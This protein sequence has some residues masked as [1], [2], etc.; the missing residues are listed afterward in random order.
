MLGDIRLDI[1]EVIGDDPAAPLLVVN[2]DREREGDGDGPLELIRGKTPIALTAR[3]LSGVV[4]I[5]AGADRS[6]PI[7]LTN[8]DRGDLRALASHLPSGPRLLGFRREIV[9][10][11]LLGRVAAA[12]APPSWRTAKARPF[13]MP[14]LS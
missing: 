12:T 3:P 8:R 2:L 11:L 10:W 9:Y 1:D 13:A 14:A 6:A 5:L 7:L 4:E